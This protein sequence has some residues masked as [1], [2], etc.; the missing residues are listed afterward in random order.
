MT[1]GIFSE[2]VA[3]IS[4]SGQYLHAN[5]GR[6]VPMYRRSLFLNVRLE[7]CYYYLFLQ[8]LS[9]QHRIVNFPQSWANK[10]STG[11]HKIEWAIPEEKVNL[12]HKNSKD[13]D[14]ALITTRRYMS[15]GTAFL[16][17]LRVHPAKNQI[18]AVWSESS[19]GIMW[20]DKDPKRLQ[21]D[22][23]ESDQTGPM[24]MQSCR[25]DCAPVYYYK[26]PNGSVSGQRIPWLDSKI[27]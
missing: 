15:R 5:L 2:V 22:N 26:I 10:P 19:Q 8:E 4:L 14:E 7:Y 21:A 20:V 13:P 27:A 11:L 24:R 6:S 1:D 9:I 23:E 16:T 25:K 18:S 17:R 12:G 3:H